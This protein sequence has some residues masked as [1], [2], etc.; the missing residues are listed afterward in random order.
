MLVGQILIST[1]AA[2]LAALL[3]AV[4]SAGLPGIL[5]AYWLTG[6]LSLLTLATWV[7]PPE[8]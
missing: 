7:Q 1:A 2:V 3:F 4:C 5:A 6:T 8:H